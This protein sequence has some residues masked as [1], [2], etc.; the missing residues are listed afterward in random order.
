[1]RLPRAPPHGFFFPPTEAGWLVL[2]ALPV[3][4]HHRWGKTWT[5]CDPGD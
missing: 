1:M 3:A 2:P 4:L 5:R